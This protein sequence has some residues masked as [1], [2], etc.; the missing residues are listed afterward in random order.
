MRQQFLWRRVLGCLLLLSAANLQAS[1]VTVTDIAGREVTLQQPAKRVILADARAIQALQIVHPQNPFAQLIAWDN[2][3]KTKAPDLYSLYLAKYPQL[4]QLPMLENAYLTDFSVERAAQ[5]HPDLIIFD[6]GVVSK[7]KESR[8]LDQLAAIGIPVLFIDFRLRPLTNSITSIRLLGKVLGDEQHS[9]AWAR[10]YEERL[11]LIRQRTAGLNEKEKPLVFI[12]RHAGMTGDECC[13]TYGKGSFGEF[14]ATAGGINVGSAL[15]AGKNGTMS[16]EQLITSNP[17]YYIMTGADWS[18]NFQQSIGI[19][20]GYD[21]DTKVTEQRLD[22]LI[23]RTG[24]ETLDAMQNKR[25]LAIYHQYYDSPLNIMAVEVIAKFL[26]PALFADLD[27]ETD[28][29]N[30]HKNVLNF[31][32]SG[33]F[34]LQAK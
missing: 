13:F 3:L 10:F 4:K 27:P 20:L 1:P 29:E 12:E 17:S 31:P 32:Y 33:T 26:H 11:K 22:H 18:S 34:W 19:P 21:A 2:T 30:I 6:F 8:V 7:L 9:E 23:K 15:F 25:V 16:L 5:M 28:I 14:I 24:I